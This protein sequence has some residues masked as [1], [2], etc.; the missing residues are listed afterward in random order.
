MIKAE[1]HK[2]LCHKLVDEN[3]YNCLNDIYVDAIFLWGKKR[4]ILDPLFYK[5]NIPVFSHSYDFNE[6]MESKGYYADTYNQL[7]NPVKIIKI[8]NEDMKKCS[9]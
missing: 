2:L 9:I 8:Y 1:Q 6:W 5:D 3:H 7:D 4:N